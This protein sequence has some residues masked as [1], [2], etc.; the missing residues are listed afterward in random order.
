[1][2]KSLKMGA[3]GL[4]LIGL[5]GC[6]MV[7]K[8]AQQLAEQAEQTLKDAARETLDGTVDA[9]NKQVDELQQSTNEWLPPAKTEEEPQPE[10]PEQSEQPEVD[11]AAPLTDQSVET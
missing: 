3:L 4:V 5:A 7:E 8:S 11:S 10:Q 1:M 9:F 2:N 6:D